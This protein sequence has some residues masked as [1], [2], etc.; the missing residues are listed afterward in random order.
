[1]HKLHMRTI[2]RKQGGRRD[3]VRP[4]FYAVCNDNYEKYHR[5]Y[6]NFGNIICNIRKT[7]LLLHYDNAHGYVHPIAVPIEL[8]SF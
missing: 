7:F 6:A 8:A 1:M 3:D 2:I 5:C 4:F